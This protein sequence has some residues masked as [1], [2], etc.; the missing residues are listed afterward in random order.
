MFLRQG[1]TAA[2][3]LGAAGLLLLASPGIV[4]ATP[5]AAAHDDGIAWYAGSIE[6]AFDAAAAAHKPLF[7]YWGAVWCPPCNELKRTIFQRREFITRTRDF[8]PVYLDGDSDSA[9]RWGEYF[10]VVGYPTV[11]ILAPDGHELTRIPGDLDISHYTETLDRVRHQLAPVSELLT[12]AGRAPQ[13]L[14]EDDWRTL[15]YYAWDEDEE[16]S[17]PAAALPEALREAAAHCPKQL[18]EAASRLFIASL[19][20]SA[21]VAEHPATALPV[22]QRPTAAAR[23]QAVLKDR[24][25]SRANAASLIEAGADLIEVVDASGAM[26]T[27]LTRALDAVLLR[28][29]D[30]AQLSTM[31]RLYTAAARI[32]V[33]RLDHAEGAV[34]AA[35]VA[36]AQQRVAWADKAATEPHER[37]SVINAALKVLLA[38]G[39]D[40]EAEHLLQAELPRSPAPYY[41]MVDLADLAQRRGDNR[42]ALDWL[43]RGYTEARGPATRFQWGLYYVQGLIEM[44]PEDRDGIQTLVAQML[45]EL[46]E[47]PDAMYQRTR[48]RLLKLDKALRQWSAAHDG[49]TTLQTLRGEAAPVCAKLP[50]DAPAQSACQSFLAGAA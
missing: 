24:A 38:A 7:L 13:S 2:L 4:S 26:R 37:Q 6:E 17:L 20:V 19:L 45:H 43:Q 32:A 11:L 49:A 33:Y 29:A 36:Q 25:L 5:A 27:S 48:Q 46:G 44:K 3:A 31:Q 40:A 28:F 16:R 39:L 50:A 23:L 12:R 8:V 18:P 1:F 34:P 9:Q 42:Q 15:A 47:H 10:G 35:L 22:A 14:H 41:F 21:S 30:D